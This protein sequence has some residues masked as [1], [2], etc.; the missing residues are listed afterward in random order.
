MASI[1]IENLNSTGKDLLLDS[2]NYLD[3]LSDESAMHVKGGVNPFT[4]FNIVEVLANLY[5]DQ[6]PAIFRR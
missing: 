4:A 5:M 2:D 6:Y 3:S 1:S